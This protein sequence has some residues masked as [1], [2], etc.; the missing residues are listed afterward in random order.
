MGVYGEQRLTDTVLPKVK[1]GTLPLSS[2]AQPIIAT[3]QGQVKRQPPEV[4]QSEIGK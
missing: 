3:I 1:A 4:L 2:L